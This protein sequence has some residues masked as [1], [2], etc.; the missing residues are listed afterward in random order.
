MNKILSIDIENNLVEVEPGV[1]CDDLY[2]KLKDYGYFFPP[3]P[4]SSSVCTVG[5]MVATNS[6]GIQAFKLA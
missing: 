5:G 1:V 4:G 3:D 6:G 2:E